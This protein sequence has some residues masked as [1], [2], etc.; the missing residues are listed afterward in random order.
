[1]YVS[2]GNESPDDASCFAVIFVGI[3]VDCEI[4]AIYSF[5]ALEM[6][7]VVVKSLGIGGSD[8][9]VHSFHQRIHFQATVTTINISDLEVST[10]TA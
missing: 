2:L 6:L 10:F 8:D 5:F 4:I 3:L 1:M 7:E 9:F